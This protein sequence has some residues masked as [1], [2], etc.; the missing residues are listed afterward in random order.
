MSDI[1][2]IQTWQQAHTQLTLAIA[3]S[4]DNISRHLTTR[5][6][7]LE[8]ITRC[9]SH[10]QPIASAKNKSEGNKAKKKTV[11]AT[12]NNSSKEERTNEQKPSGSTGVKVD[13]KP[14]V[15]GGTSAAPP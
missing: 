3:Q 6:Y 9:K 13:G 14:A 11:P 5:R 1:Q 4:R 8:E 2:D 15:T 12:A 7:L 10:H